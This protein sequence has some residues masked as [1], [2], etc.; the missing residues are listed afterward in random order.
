MV[1]ETVGGAAPSTTVPTLEVELNAT[2]TPKMLKA[3]TNPASPTIAVAV[4]GTVLSVPNIITPI[5]GSFRITGDH[6]DPAYINAI[7]TVT[8][9]SN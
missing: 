9:Q 1:I 6:T 8:G 7:T 2:G 4:N 5:N 3:T